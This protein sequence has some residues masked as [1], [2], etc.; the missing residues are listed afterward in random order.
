MSIL[1]FF[2][3]FN[4][5]HYSKDVYNLGESLAKD[6]SYSHY[7]LHRE[8]SNILKK[9]K[10]IYHLLDYLTRY[11]PSI[12]EAKPTILIQFHLRIATVFT[13]LL[14]IFLKGTIFIIKADTGEISI[15]EGKLFNG[16][17]GK[18]TLILLK[19]L[20]Q[21]AG[22]RVIIT[23]ET[24]QAV[25]IFN[26]RHRLYNIQII[27]L[28]N[29]ACLP[30]G[31]LTNKTSRNEITTIGFFDQNKNLDL[32]LHSL[33]FLKK[34]DSEILGK[35]NVNII[36]PIE[37]SSSKLISS[38]GLSNEI[39]LLGPITDRKKI[40]SILCK[41]SV[42]VLT[43]YSEGSPLVFSE[44]A[45]CGCSIVSTP[46]NSADFYTTITNGKMT[47]SFCVEEFTQCLASLMKE[48]LSKD[49]KF[50]YHFTWE[51]TTKQL[52]KVIKSK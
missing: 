16:I 42:L 8:N 45:L 37:E 49:F 51:N 41:T 17:K 25:K 28:N 52:L 14:L 11:Y 10:R 4:Q 21:L 38:L 46:V 48:N 18:S 32:L 30:I 9:K 29:G 31:E 43:S 40:A 23:F 3:R 39:N 13:T 27:E 2:P 44:A 26:E 34:N 47:R 19:L 50:N 12:L 22:S 35:Y 20:D 5:I 24:K 15:K 7:V 33:F 36:G 6:L 1:T